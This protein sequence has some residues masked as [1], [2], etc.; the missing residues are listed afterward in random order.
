MK[1]LIAEDDKTSRKILAS[2][3]EKSGHEVVQA[4]DGEEA[5]QKMQE[6]GAPGMLLLD[7]MMPVMDGLELCRNIRSFYKRTQPYIIMV[8]GL[9]GEDD[10]VHGLQEAGADDYVLK[11]YNFR[12]LNARILAGQRILDMQSRLLTEISQRKRA[13]SQLSQLNEEL[14][15]VFHGTQD[16]MFLISV[17]GEESFRFIRNNKTHQTL[18]GISLETIRNKTPEELLG[19]ELGRKISENYA[20]CVKAGQPVSYEETLD[21]PGGRRTWITTLNPVFK[22]NKAQHI[23]G[24]SQ[25]ITERK[26]LEKALRE[27]EKKLRNITD[28]MGEG[29]YVMD[30]QGVVTFVN[31]AASELLGYAEEDILGRIGHDLFHVHN[32]Q[33]KKVPLKHCP[34]YH[35][36]SQGKTYRDE[37]FF[38]RRDKSIFPVEVIGSPMWENGQ[39]VGSVNAFF[40]ITHRKSIE[41]SL[42]ESEERFR[43]SLENLPGAVFVHDLEGRFLL[44]NRA[45]CQQTG[46]SRKDLLKMNVGD[47][48]PK[49]PTREDILY[50]WKN[51]K[52]G[53]SSKIESFHTTRDGTQYP[54]EVF[55]DAIKINGQP[56]MLAVAFDISQRK[57][58]EEKLSLMATTDELTGMWNRRHF[59][60]AV[61]NALE[62]A[63][64]YQEIFSLLMLDIDHFKKINDTHGHAAGDAVLRH[65]AGLIRQSLRQVDLAG[66]FGGE[67]F[68]VILPHTDLDGAYVI[69]ERLRQCIKNQPAQYND[70]EIPLSVSIG[71]ASYHETIKD[72]DEIFKM[73]D[74]ALYEAKSKGRDLVVTCKDQCSSSG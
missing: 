45:A 38:Q 56:A 32:Q 46:Y 58:A 12:E 2:G 37:D 30:K 68:A 71:V 62:R 53:Q 40:D 72:E 5:W 74:D 26:Q 35:A 47:I 8:T 18:T 16:A 31:P 66:R 21:L 13:Q 64:R 29:I 44:V 42:R 55:I 24:S 1:I 73:A 23:V 51:T 67:E 6:P 11:P 22:E 63:H 48:D 4:S 50:I 59:T 33:G 9:T 17:E 15:Q 19:E 52:P 25:D 3:L 14:E 69:A 49:A 27:N 36:V 43:I 54:A 57:A 28:T 10:I 39:V 7:I 70:M 65:F 20:K 41:E 61:R 34:I 60:K